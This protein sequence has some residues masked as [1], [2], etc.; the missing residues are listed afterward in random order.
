M[1]QL[2][3]V[4]IYESFISNE[5]PDLV[6]LQEFSK[7]FSQNLKT[8]PINTMPLQ[9]NGQNG[10]CIL[11][12]YPLVNRGQL[13]FRILIIAVFLLTFYKKDA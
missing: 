12:K 7:E 11:S 2:K 6:C 8:I 3:S 4:R 1:D 10:L 5:N 9:K 13:D